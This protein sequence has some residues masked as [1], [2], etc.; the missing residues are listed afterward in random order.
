MLQLDVALN[1]TFRYMYIDDVSF[2][3]NKQLSSHVDSMY[4][5]YEQLKSAV[6]FFN[7][8]GCTVFFLN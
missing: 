2:I 4:I 6:Q 8:V 7:V 1:S 3:N 5:D